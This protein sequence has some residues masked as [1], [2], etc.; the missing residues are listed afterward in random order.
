MAALS[1]R[2]L[3][4]GPTGRLLALGLTVL[5][6]VL[7]W[8]VVAEPLLDAY[9]AGE[10]SL[11]QQVALQG[12]M[13]DLADSL[14][15]LR[16][17]AALAAKAGPPPNTTLAGASDAI[18]TASLQGLL[19]NMAG[20]AG[21]HVTSAEALPAEQQ[22][23]YRRVSLRLSVDATWPT[24]VALLQ[25]IERATPRMFVDD[26]QVH[27]QPVS[28]RQR[29]L[30]LDI[31]FTVLAFRGPGAGGSEPVPGTPAATP[32]QGGEGDSDQ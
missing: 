5:L 24:L 31:A 9:Q 10:E 7:A 29:E 4:E 13:Q 20:A 26:L 28:E 8:V 15:A 14:P 16:R 1:A 21:A 23:A 25:A 32:D 6:A 19:E 30:P 2:A 27:A 12:R 3:P 11:R 17:E 22:G 18:A